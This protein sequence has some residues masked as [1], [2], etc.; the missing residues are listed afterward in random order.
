MA[1]DPILE[2][3]GL[4]LGF[5]AYGHTTQVLHGIDLRVQ[6]GQRVAVIGESGSG[7]TVTM[8]AVIGTLPRPAARVMAGSIRFQGREL[9]TL[10]RKER[11]RLKGTDISIVHQD[12]L[13]SIPFSRSASIWTTSCASPTG[14]WAS[15]RTTPEGSAGP[16]RHSAR[17][18]SRNRN[19][20][21]APIPSSFPEACASAC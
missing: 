3:R 13:T 17:S 2:I 7:K 20:S 15:R 11:D 5:A 4:D 12:P 1:G 19:G 6:A 10:P 14:G 8:K 18:S 16:W 21:F 9:L